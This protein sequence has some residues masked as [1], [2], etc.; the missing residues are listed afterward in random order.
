MK[1]S[2]SLQQ[3]YNLFQHHCNSEFWGLLSIVSTALVLNRGHVL[4]V[5][6]SCTVS[7]HVIE[8]K[9]EHVDKL[10]AYRWHDTTWYANISC[11]LRNWHAD[12]SVYQT[13][14]KLKISKMNKTKLQKKVECKKSK[15]GVRS[16]WSQCDDWWETACGGEVL[17]KK[18][19]LILEWKMDGESRDNAVVSMSTLTGQ[20]FV[21]LK[22]L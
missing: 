18:W 19:V 20:I 7:K 2:K 6:A 12:S 8:I 1:T 4:G 15:K 11:V 5:T 14:S 3:K 9:A 21:V 17:W 13:K 22:K 10:T 16:P